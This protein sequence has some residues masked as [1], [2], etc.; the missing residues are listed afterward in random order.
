MKQAPTYPLP[1][2]WTLYGSTDW[3]LEY[4]KRAPR[5]PRHKYETLA[6]VT[7]PWSEAAG[8]VRP[9]SLD[10]GLIKACGSWRA[11]GKRWHYV[12]TV[13]D[14]SF[15]DGASGPA[16]D[17]GTMLAALL[18]DTIYAAHRNGLLGD[19]NFW[20]SFQAKLAAD[21]CYGRMIEERVEHLEEIGV[22]LDGIE[23]IGKARNLWS[24]A[25]LFVGGW[26]AW[27]KRRRVSP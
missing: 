14:G 16:I 17:R 9:F 18:H 23:R 20:Q 26:P 6:T 12:I 15:F 21:R 22:D 24:R 19:R 7:A 8:W 2:Y 25:G 4:S 27:R 11:Y 10:D 5:S 1:E 13:E 3:Y